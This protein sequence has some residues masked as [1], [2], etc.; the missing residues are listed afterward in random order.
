[1]YTLLVPLAMAQKLSQKF[2]KKMVIKLINLHVKNISINVE[3]SFRFTVLF[4]LP[5]RFY[6]KE[7]IHVLV[8][9]NSLWECVM[10]LQL[11]YFYSEGTGEKFKFNIYC[12]FKLLNYMYQNCYITLWCFSMNQ[13]RYMYVTLSENF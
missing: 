10:L 6:K 4:K 1:M 8:I 2:C 12:T 3:L 11:G 5:L 13:F 9:K 7:I